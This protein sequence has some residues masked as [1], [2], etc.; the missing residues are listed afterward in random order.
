MN[1]KTVIWVSAVFAVIIAA[2]LALVPVQRKAEFNQKW[3]ELAELY[4]T[5]ERAQYII[6]NEELYPD[7]ILKYFYNDKNNLDFVYNYA[8]HKDD[9][10]LMEYFPEELNGE[11]IPALY[12]DDYRWCYQTFGDGWTIKSSGCAAVS[13]TMAYLYLTGKPDYDPYKVTLIAENSGQIG[14]M[15]GGIVS[16]A[17]PSVAEEMGLTAEEYRFFEDN[18]KTENVQKDAIEEMIDSGNVVMAGIMGKTFGDHA[19]IIADYNDKGF[20]INDPA[21]RENSDKIWAYD[22]IAGEIYYLWA[23]KAGE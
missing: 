2:M 10:A 23:L 3:G 9:Y 16:S 17:V 11:K 1:K 8:F 4:E 6:D 20:I 13:L 21:S 18:K 19:V 14:F 15:N 22:E 5:D 12:M 7:R